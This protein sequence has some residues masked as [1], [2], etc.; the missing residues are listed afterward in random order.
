MLIAPLDTENGLMD[1]SVTPP[2]WFRYPVGSP[3]VM[4]RI[5][6]MP[7]PSEKPPATMGKITLIRAEVVPTP[8]VGAVLVATQPVP[9]SYGIG[10][11]VA[12][13]IPD[14]RALLDAGFTILEIAHMRP[15]GA[16]ESV[17]D[18]D[19]IPADSPEV[20][21]YIASQPGKLR[22]AL[23]IEFRETRTGA[24]IIDPPRT[25]RYPFGVQPNYTPNRDRLA[26]EVNARR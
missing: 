23:E 10:L 25:L 2:A 4:H 22:Y 26:A 15:G 19:Q 11:D 7:D 5:K 21:R 3:L 1:D 14:M 20:I 12:L 9:V 18:F 8:P 17:L 24:G 13:T 16:L 6:V